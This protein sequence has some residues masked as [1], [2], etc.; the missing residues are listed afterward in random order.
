MDRQK[1]KAEVLYSYPDIKEKT[2]FKSR[3]P[4]VVGILTETVASDGATY[5]HNSEVVIEKGYNRRTQEVTISK[6]VVIKSKLTRNGKV[7]PFSITEKDL[8]DYIDF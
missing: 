4:Q 2:N 1:L 3:R 8:E 5:L 7:P 6:V